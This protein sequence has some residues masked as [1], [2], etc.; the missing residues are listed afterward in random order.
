[1]LKELYI[2]NMRSYENGIYTYYLTSLPST[3]NK[4][5]NLEVL[6]ASY[7]GIEGL[8]DLTN[9]TKLTRLQLNNNKITDLKIDAPVSN[10]NRSN[11]SYYFN[12]SNNPYISCVEVP[13]SEVTNWETRYSQYSTIAD[14]GIA[15]S[16]S[17]TGFRVPQSEREALVAIY[18]ATNGGEKIDATTGVTW[19]GTNWSSDATELTNVGSWEGVTTELINGQKHVTK[20]ELTYYKNLSGSIPKEI[21]DLTELTRLDLSNGGITSIAT[22]IGDLSKLTYLNLSSNKLTGLPVG[23]GNFTSLE[24]LN[25]TSQRENINT[26]QYTATLTSLPDE[27]GNIATLEKLDLSYNGLTSLPSGIGNFTNLKELKLQY[28]NTSPVRYQPTYTLASLPDE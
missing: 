12:I 15:F 5:T 14:N 18:K 27:I 26:S 25:L 1:S 9:V 22:E 11:V 10:F 2:E 16:D 21:K 19:V 17:C 8:V 24:E 20:I 3:M 13:T 4:L 6:E 28:Q 7:S 23:I